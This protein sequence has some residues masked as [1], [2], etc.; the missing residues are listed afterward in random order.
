MHINLTDDGNND[1]DIKFCLHNSKY[2]SVIRFP[3]GNKLL[4]GYFETLEEAIEAKLQKLEELES[5]NR[6]FRSL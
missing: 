5:N 4:V 3:N 2:E 6:T 1:P